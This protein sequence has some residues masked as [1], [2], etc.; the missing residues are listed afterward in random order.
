MRLANDL[1]KNVQN[2][3]GTSDTRI[4]SLEKSYPA[5]TLDDLK[6]PYIA[7]SYRGNG[8]FSR[9]V[10]Q[11]RATDFKLG[12]SATPDIFRIKIWGMEFSLLHELIKLWLDHLASRI[13]RQYY[14]GN[15][16]AC[17]PSMKEGRHSRT[18]TRVPISCHSSSFLIMIY[19]KP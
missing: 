18:A 6:S 1:E 5:I 2:W 17:L 19:P 14:R 16:R 10:C 13:V 4:F 7:R 8:L 11:R 9:K 15:R 3:N 12:K